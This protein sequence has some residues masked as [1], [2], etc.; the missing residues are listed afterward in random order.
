MIRDFIR[1]L[2]RDRRGNVAVTF[3]L[4]SI[5]LLGVAGA[6]IDYSVAAMQR[7]QLLAAA[8]A[9]SVGAVSQAS[10][11]MQTALSM[12]GDGPISAGVTDATTIFNNNARLSPGAAVSS[13]TVSVTKKGTT[14][15]SSVQ[16]AAAVPTMFLGIVG[17]K[18]FTVSDSS[19]AVS[20]VPAYMDFY[21]LLDD[22]PSMGIGASQSD[23]DRMQ[24]ANGCAFACHAPA[25]GFPG[26]SIP[27]VPG[28]QLRIDV[29]RQATSQLISTAMQKQVV[30][31]QFRMG[32][33]TFAN[34]VTT[35][36]NLTTNLSQVQTM[37]NNIQLP[38]SRQGTQ[39]GD[40][41][42]WLQKNA[43]TSASG[44]GSAN[45]PIK[46]VFLVT[47]GVEDF[48]DGYQP[49]NYDNLP[50]QMGLWYG[51]YIT[52]VMISDACKTLKNK[53]VTVAVLYTT[54][55]VITDFR[56]TDLVQPFANNISPA[57]Q[58]CASPGY[59]FQASDANGLNTAL[60]QMFAQAIAQPRLS[61]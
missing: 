8:D 25:N 57:L 20:T 47:D 5:P 38:T 28:T 51:Q 48:G 7:N 37:T 45:Q 33:Y 4:L 34:T 19:T 49:G 12:S 26:Y 31:S 10:P 42:D 52:G 32:L 59:F 60:Q 35:L 22:S 21:L 44:N 17:I 29:L 6:G 2:A 3:G 46:F 27:D 30:A 14:V 50:P 13:L 41:I 55:A 39:I 16:F 11:A 54:Y 56:Y 15:T 24:A 18:S 9:A 23:I 61:Q 58:A 53:G 36:S 1:R 43:V 40:S